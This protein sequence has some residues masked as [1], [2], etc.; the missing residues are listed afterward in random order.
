VIE[1]KAAS[2]GQSLGKNIAARRKFLGLTQ[3]TLAEKLGIDTITVSRFER[4]SHLPSLLRLEQIAVTLEMSVAQ[5]FSESSNL[6]SDQALLAQ[7]LL[8]GLSEADRQLVL[9][10]LNVWCGRLRKAKQD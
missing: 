10:M 8:A 6:L 9:S 4:G 1:N 7:N 3:A 5:L 2:L